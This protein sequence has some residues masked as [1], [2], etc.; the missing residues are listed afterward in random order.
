M[1]SVNLGGQLLYILFIPQ[2]DFSLEENTGINK[3]LRN[4]TE[5]KVVHF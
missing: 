2:W 1:L 4:Q 3:C 5:V